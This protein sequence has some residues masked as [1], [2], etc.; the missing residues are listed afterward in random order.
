[1][2]WPVAADMPRGP[3]GA[4]LATLGMNLAALVWFIGSALGL[5]VVAAMRSRQ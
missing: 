4:L 2:I 1:M 3:R 5:V